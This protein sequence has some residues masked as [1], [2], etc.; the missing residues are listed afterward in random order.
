M[1]P[2][3]TGA[4]V[5]HELRRR[6]LRDPEASLAC[7]LLVRACEEADPQCRH[8]TRRERAEASRAAREARPP[9]DAAFVA[10]RARILVGLLTARHGSLRRALHAVRVRLPAL[11][12]LALAVAAG[13][14]ADALGSG[15]RVNLLAF[16]L[17]V[18]LAWNLGAYLVLALGPLATR[19]SRVAGLAAALARLPLQLA[20][21]HLPDGVPGETRWLGDALRRFGAAW[22]AAAGPVLAA[23]ARRLLHVGALGFAL[24]IV[25]GMYVRGLAFEYRASWESTFLD[26]SQVSGLLGAVLG[27]AAR[28]LDA[29]RPA[30]QPRATELLQTTSLEALRA[31][32]G[33]GPA[34]TWIHLWALTA[35]A[36]IGLPRALLAWRAGRRARRLARG[37]APDLGEPYFLRLRA[38]DRG[39]GVRIE[40]LPYSHRPSPLATDALLELLHELVGNRAQITL[41]EPLAYGADPPA[42]DARRGE[43]HGR[44]VVLNLAQSPEQ[45]V[46]GAFLE[47]LRARHAAAPHPPWLLVLLDEEG[48]R[49]RQGDAPGRDRV[50][51]RWRAWERVARDA[52]LRLAALRPLAAD[53]DAALEEARAAIWP[54]ASGVA[55]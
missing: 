31:P 48:F 23:R 34:A 40:V 1:G 35:A 26:A 6:V 32:A 4:G 37:L 29:L 11:P 28:G 10:E 12:V 27:P 20:R 46:H 36:A 19:R 49:A 38:F 16:P 25:A 55:A 44:V 41:V 18:L 42:A 54:A 14:A 33:D 52:E 22:V 39:E 47:A 43:P 3:R 13:L 5:A 50:A 53:A 17:L 7:I 21:L 9:D 30:A 45:E 2:G 15:R 24:G 51:E 8:V